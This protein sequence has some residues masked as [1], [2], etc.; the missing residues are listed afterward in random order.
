MVMFTKGDIASGKIMDAGWKVAEI[1]DISAT[2]SKG[3]KEGFTA[4]FSI[5]A[6]SK[7]EGVEVPC[8]YYDR[9]GMGNYARL[10]KIL[11]GHEP[12][13]GIKYDEKAMTDKKLKIYTTP[14][15]NP[16]NGNPMNS[17]NDYTDITNTNAEVRE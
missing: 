16:N 2:E 12:E 17:V 8:W 9:V 6:P 7:Y 4:Y 1:I 3:G 5:L 11:L 10:V 14:G 13:P 15:V